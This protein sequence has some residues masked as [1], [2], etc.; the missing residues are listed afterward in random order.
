MY[1]CLMLLLNTI[2][3][4]RKYAVSQSVLN[5]YFNSDLLIPAL[6][7][8]FLCLLL[9]WICPGRVFEMYKLIF[10][11]I[12]LTGRPLAKEQLI[13]FWLGSKTSTIRH[14]L[15]NLQIQ[16][17][18]KQILRVFFFQSEGIQLTYTR[19]D[20]KDVLSR[21]FCFSESELMKVWTRTRTEA[22][23]K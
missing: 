6:A 7:Q 13:I 12:S 11:N 2:H 4:P 18:L 8:L 14:L 15:F 10:H 22:G 20:F 9:K 17:K 23:K 5:I 16:C 21:P 1:S 3:W 19:P